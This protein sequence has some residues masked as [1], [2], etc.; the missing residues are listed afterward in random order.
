MSRRV[1]SPLAAA[2]V[3]LAAAPALADQAGHA[4]APTAAAPVV[5]SVAAPAAPKPDAGY[6]RMQKKLDELEARVR[7]AEAKVAE[8]YR[9]APTITPPDSHSESW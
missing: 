5:A 9:P 6:D 4:G 8:M 7:V 2:A 1:L 3:L